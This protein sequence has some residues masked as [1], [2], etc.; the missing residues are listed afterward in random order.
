M[1]RK[2][3]N[4]LEHP[5]AVGITMPKANNAQAPQSIDARDKLRTA[6]AGLKLKKASQAA[7]EHVVITGKDPATGQLTVQPVDSN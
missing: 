4:K 2:V 7:E 3:S 5:L 6:R 1:E